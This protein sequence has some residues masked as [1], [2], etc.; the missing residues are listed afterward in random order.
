MADFL[1]LSFQ[2]FVDPQSQ[3]EEKKEI[4]K[5]DSKLTLCSRTGKRRIHD[6]NR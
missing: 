1:R 3:I 2:V 5:A 4:E 6:K